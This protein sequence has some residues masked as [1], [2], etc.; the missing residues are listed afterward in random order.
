MAEEISS[1]LRL[2]RPAS[3]ISTGQGSSSSHEIY[4]ATWL[5]SSVTSF[6]DRSFLSDLL[7]RFRLIIKKC[8]LEVHENSVWKNRMYLNFFILKKPGIR[9]E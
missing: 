1:H 3:F 9:K 2:F 6:A 8:I 5:L 7:I 4:G